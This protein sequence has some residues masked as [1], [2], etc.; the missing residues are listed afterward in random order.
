MRYLWG[1]P[2][3]EDDKEEDDENDEDDKEKDDEDNKEKDEE[4]EDDGQSSVGISFGMSGKQ[5]KLAKADNAK[6]VQQVTFSFKYR[7]L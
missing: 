3:D 1:C 7:E 4:D 5:S 6:K 2:D